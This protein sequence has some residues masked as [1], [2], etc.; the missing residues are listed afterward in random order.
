MT[1][2]ITIAIGGAIGAIL[3]F[4]V[5]NAVYSL[6]GKTFPWGTLV[7]NVSGSLFMGF[8]YV[9]FV[10]RMAVSVEIRSLI[11]VGLLGAFTTFSTFSI[12]TLDLIE[13]GEL[14][15]AGLNMFLSVFCCIAACWL[16]LVV[17]RQL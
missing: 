2:L 17:G 4:S 16:G 14:I 6:L 9:M 8:L 15:R 5:S 7:V 13:S 11:L 12:E 1:Q 3:R 10:E